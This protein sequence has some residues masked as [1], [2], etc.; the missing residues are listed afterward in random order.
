MRRIHNLS[1]DMVSHEWQHFQRSG[2][3]VADC[4]I[5]ATPDRLHKDPAVALAKLG[6]LEINLSWIF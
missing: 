4:A 1:D 2:R 3:K 5:I 6:G